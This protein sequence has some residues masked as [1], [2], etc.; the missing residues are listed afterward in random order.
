[1]L[2]CIYVYIYTHI[3]VYTLLC[4]FMKRCTYMR[5]STYVCAYMYI[6]PR[7]YVYIYIYMSTCKNMQYY[8]HKAKIKD[9]YLR[10][11]FM[12]ICAE[13]MRIYVND[14]CLFTYI[15]GSCCSV[16]QCVAVCCSVLQC[17]ALR[18]IHVYSHIYTYIWLMS[19][20]IYTI[21]VYTIH[22]YSHTYNSCPFACIQ[23]I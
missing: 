21:C 14:S 13:R 7:I 18:T 19:I 8:I 9:P 23:A 3:C 5:I 15:Y 2:M 1:M 16:L 6:R 11:R 17:V 12:S 22:V 20:H 10:V 4:M